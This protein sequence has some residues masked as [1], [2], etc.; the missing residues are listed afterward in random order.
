MSN[1]V[2]INRVIRKSYGWDIHTAWKQPLGPPRPAFFV[3]HDSCSPSSSYFESR[4]PTAIMVQNEVNLLVLYSLECQNPVRRRAGGVTVCRFTREFFCWNIE[5]LRWC[6]SP[7]ARLRT[8]PVGCRTP[9]VDCYCTGRCSRMGAADNSELPD[10]CL[11]T[12]FHKCKARYPRSDRRTWR[13]PTA[14]QY[15]VE[16]FK[17]CRNIL[18]F[19]SY[20]LHLVHNRSNLHFVAIWTDPLGHRRT[21]HPRVL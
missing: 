20:W 5:F 17:L 8:L 4:K 15:C 1:T 10:T 9:V 14:V 19:R 3:V 11:P 16:Q 21:I 18:Y 12:C 6:V 13:C 7:F 2:M